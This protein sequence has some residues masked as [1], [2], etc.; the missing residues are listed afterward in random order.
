[1]RVFVAGGT[2]AIGRF[3]LPELVAGG[4]KVVALVRSEEKR[5]QVEAAGARAAFAD[6]LD[7]IGLTAAIRMA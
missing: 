7:P 5:K 1:M 2:G 3:L 6:A 4:H